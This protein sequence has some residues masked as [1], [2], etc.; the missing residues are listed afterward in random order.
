MRQNCS[1]PST[2]ARMW[3]AFIR[4]TWGTD[5]RRGGYL[6]AHRRASSNCRSGPAS[7]PAARRS[8]SSAVRTLSE[9]RSPISCCKNKGANAT[10][11]ICHLPVQKHGIPHETGGH[12]DRCRRKTEGYYRRYG[13][14][15]GRGD[16]CRREPIGVTPEGKA[17]LCGD[18][19]FEIV[20]GERQA[21]LPRFLAASAR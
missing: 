7:G 21:P 19:D 20:K 8:W 18:V 4:S 17:K 2:P 6:P 5:D 1:S 3:T 15:G 13:E 10:V 16:R 14:G 9:S 11:T 12:P